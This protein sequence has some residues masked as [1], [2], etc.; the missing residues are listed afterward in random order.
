MFR[1]HKTFGNYLSYVK[2]GCEMEGASIDV[3]AHASLKR[4]KVAIEKRRR[5]PLGPAPFDML[6]VFCAGC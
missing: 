6:N 1:C 3:F 5:V 2:L 4:A